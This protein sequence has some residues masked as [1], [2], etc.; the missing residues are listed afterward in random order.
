M[1]VTDR[2]RTMVAAV[3]AAGVC[4]S[5]GA[6]SGQETG[7][8]PVPSAV[9]HAE[10]LSAAF[11]HASELVLP[12]V[13]RITSTT[14]ARQ[15][16]GGAGRRGQLPPGQANP[17]EGTPFEELFKEEFGDRLGLDGDGLI[18]S[19]QGLG[20]G[21]IIAKD[22]LVLTN[23]H[24]VE[25]ADEVTIELADGRTFKAKDIRTDKPTDIAILR[26]EDS[27][28]FPV[29]QLGN[30]DQLQIGDWVLAIG[31]PFGVGVSVS[32]GIISGKE[33]TLSEVERTS[34][35]QT[36]AAVNPGNSGGP[37][38]NLRGEVIGINTAIAT[39]T[40]GYQGISFA[41]P[42]NTAKWVIERLVESGSV[43][44]A[45]LGVGIN[46][47]TADIAAQLELP[48]GTR[49]VF[50]TYVQEGK[51][52]A[53]AGIEPQDVIIAIDGKPVA[54]PKDLQGIIE[55][56]PIGSDHELEILRGGRKQKLTVRLDDYAKRGPAV[57]ADEERPELPMD[58][59][60]GVTVEDLTP[61]LAAQL[62]MEG[63][64][65]AVVTQVA[66]GSVAAQSGLQRGM[67]ITRAGSKAVEDAASFEAAVKDA[68]LDKG[69]FVTV[70]IPGGNGD[71]QGTQVLLLKRR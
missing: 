29:A 28:L 49:G 33:R 68:S 66:R 25:G 13:V 3:L 35:L 48:K 24:V 20:S 71:I 34:F 37:L 21:V 7:T 53:K 5:S 31:Q 39:R 10:G 55:R 61:D 15:A 64:R 46:E 19:Q 8:K 50:V 57:A 12:A 22:G 43:Q 32:A 38:V 27:E 60:L 58:N 36:D 54:T 63:R 67:V 26:I 47:L 52:A 23:N 70:L 14:K 65:G 41:L 45:Y 18:P 30:S 51:P 69:L 59:E 6:V 11:R 56:L 62:G 1:L 9:E 2:F 16:R 44:R 17:F 42:I 40:G 4:L